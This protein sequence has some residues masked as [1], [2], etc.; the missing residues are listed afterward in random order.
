VGTAH[1]ILGTK[2][3]ILCP[4]KLI[5]MKENLGG[6]GFQPVLAQAKPCGFI[7]IDPN[8]LMFCTN[9]SGQI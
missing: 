3:H 6:T 9:L 4:E 8:R 5:I 1:E 7:F 2:N